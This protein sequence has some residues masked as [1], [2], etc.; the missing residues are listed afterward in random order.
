TRLLR[1]FGRPSAKENTV[2]ARIYKIP[3]NAMQ[4]GTALTDKWMLEFEP[5]EQRKRDPLTG[6]AGSGD[7]QRQVYLNFPD[8]APA[9][10]YAD[11]FSIPYV[12]VSTAN[13]VLKIQA[14]AD[15]FR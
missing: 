11:N 4:S 12:F 10:A 15:N 14:Y 9:L 2:A 8:I 5:S 3:M 1:I 13:Q 6:W 7:T